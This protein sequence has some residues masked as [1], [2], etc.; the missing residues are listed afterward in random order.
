[1]GLSLQGALVTH[2]DVQS[3]E[4]FLF[5]LTPRGER[6]ARELLQRG[7][8]LSVPQARLLKRLEPAGEAGVV[9]PGAQGGTARVLRDEV[10]PPLIEFV[11]GPALDPASLAGAAPEGLADGAPSG[12]LE[13]R[14]WR[15]QGRAHLVRTQG[16]VMTLC[17]RNAGTAAWSEA[18]ADAKLCEDCAAE[19]GPSPGVPAAPRQRLTAAGRAW[20]A[21][22]RAS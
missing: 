3:P 12:Q 2:A 20:L 13:R 11:P 5:T 19:S 1:M 15:R 9:V 16:A 21:Q 22:G 10:V 7:E 4:G 18:P 17:R 14:W 6:I 8:A